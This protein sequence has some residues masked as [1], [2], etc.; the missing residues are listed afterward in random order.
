M[1]RLGNFPK[2]NGFGKTCIEHKGGSG[3]QGQREIQD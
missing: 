1:H 3:A 2:A